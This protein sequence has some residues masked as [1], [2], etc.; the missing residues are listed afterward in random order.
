MR[1]IRPKVL[2]NFCFAVLL[3]VVCA[4]YYP[5]L[6]GN[7][8]YD[9]ASNITQNHRL[10]VDS[11]S[12]ASL[13]Q[14]AFS[15][16]SGPLKRPVSMLS[17]WASYYTGG[18]DAGW[19]K[20]TNLFIHLV[21]G[22]L[23]LWLSMLLLAALRSQHET[24]LNDRAV[25]WAAL[26]AATI[27][28][29]HPLALTNVLYVVQRM[30][31]LSAL[32]TLAGLICYVSGRLRVGD[33]KPG[34]ARIVLGLLGFGTLATLSKE[35]GV[36]LPFY[37]LAIELTI[38]AGPATD[39]N[40]GRS[41]VRWIL[42]AT[43]VIPVLLFTGFLLTH[44]DWLARHY[45]SHSFSLVQRVL[46]EPR[47]LW[48]YVKWI[49]VPD[50]REF[51]LTHDDIS[52]ST[53]LLAP[54]STLLSVTA[55]AAVFGIAIAVRKRAP[56]FSL[57]VFWFLFGHAM[58]SSILALDITYEHRNY[59]PMFGPLFAFSYLLAGPLARQSKAIVTVFAASLIVVLALVTGLRASEWKDGATMRLFQ[60][61]HHPQSARANYE[62]GYALGTLIL[63]DPI[64][65][66]VYYHQ[67]ATY[68]KN[69]VRLDSTAVNGY[70]GL[71]LLNQ[72]NGGSIDPE[73]MSEVK[74]RLSTV[75]LKFTVIEP[76]RKLTDWVI[77]G[78]V[79]LPTSEVESLFRAAISNPTASAGLK[80]SLF[81][82][83]SAYYANAEHNMQN[84]VT[85]AIA[86]TKQAPGEPAYHLSLA[87]LAI[88]LQNY[89][90]ARKELREAAQTDTFN[91]FALKVEAL[92]RKLDDRAAPGPT[93]EG[94]IGA[95]G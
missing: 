46:T 72:V 13:W 65:S 29:V 30:N 43:T 12:P 7:F 79:E 54:Y 67:A 91:R 81:S 82:L 68:F 60:V 25:R 58:E 80:A 19:F 59:L 31:S 4:A 76:F 63:G 2:W 17:L 9:D 14:A 75:P 49:A 11:V 53:G 66:A 86:A 16:D 90:F 42:T 62:A 52:I 89:E 94:P 40:P 10:Q 44:T 57:A 55:W 45:D 70:F 83:L 71:I 88:V 95:S 18:L 36:L 6:G 64:S 61:R 69:S 47:I 8:L 92:K 32:F 50:L 28:L 56:V 22:C 24:Q 21:N 87:D 3:I 48:M 51:G 73:D 34:I 1:L 33:G 35:N 93:A 23:L 74:Y 26:L 41:A 84:A 78:T 27:W 39:E 5:G 85:F 38:F 20:K 15:S 37:M 77:K